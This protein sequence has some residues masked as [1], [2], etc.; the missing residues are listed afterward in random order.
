MPST[1]EAALLAL[2]AA[3]AGH[4]ATVLREP[5]LPLEYPAGGLVNLAPDS[6][7]EEGVRL[8]TGVREWSRDV[9]L[10]HVVQ[11]ADAEERDADIDAAMRQTAALLLSDRTLGGA[12]D[13]LELSAPKE[14]D[15]VPM[16]GA[17][18]LKGAVLV[19]TLF[20]ETTL[21]PME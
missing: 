17:E 11:G 12:V 1:H 9:D 3:L 21:N 2:Q 5:D 4:A 20:Y 18:T 16:P 19:A 7:V 6:P 15:S 8:G 10:E 14:S 13:W